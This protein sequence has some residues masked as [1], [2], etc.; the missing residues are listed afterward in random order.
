MFLLLIWHP[1]EA[2]TG[3]RSLNT[4]VQEYIMTFKN[5]FKNSLKEHYFAFLYS[6]WDIKKLY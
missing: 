5:I 3:K 4:P 2:L 1:T 6:T